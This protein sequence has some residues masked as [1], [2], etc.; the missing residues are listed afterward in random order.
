MSLTSQELDLVADSERRQ[1]DQL[2]DQVR[3]VGSAGLDMGSGGSCPKPNCE[4]WAADGGSGLQRV[5]GLPRFVWHVS[6]G[7][8]SRC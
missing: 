1:P 4:T 2:V 3:L 5:P 6:N 7:A 8:E